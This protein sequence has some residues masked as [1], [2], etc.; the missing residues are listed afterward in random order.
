MATIGTL[1]CSRVMGEIRPMAQR[2]TVWQIPGQNGYGV[3][4]HGLGHGENQF[5]AVAYGSDVLTGGVI[6]LPTW[7]TSL[8]ALQGTV[9]TIVND[10]G[11]SIANQ[12]IREVGI[13]KSQTAWDLIGITRRL[14]VPVQTLTV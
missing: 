14:E 3:H 7:L 6:H 5:T 13:P 9:V 2:M 1:F 10:Q 11:V 12:L 8:R 4:L